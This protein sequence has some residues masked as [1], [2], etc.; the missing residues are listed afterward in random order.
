MG[1]V[2]AWLAKKVL[3]VAVG[4]ILIGAACAIA[5]AAVMWLWHDYLDAKARVA[6]LQ[7]QKAELIEIQKDT[8]RLHQ[9]AEA[10][11]RSDL[12]TA[13]ATSQRRAAE[14][15]SLQAALERVRTIE[16]PSNE[17]ACP[18]HPA[19]LFALGR[20]RQGAGTDD[21]PGAAAVRP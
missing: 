8:V 20:L 7:T 15:Q 10:Q 13:R 3:G 18:V 12:V 21:P 14:T 2:S 1:A 19:I 17:K 5:S 6:V 16:R 9:L 4:K 11:L